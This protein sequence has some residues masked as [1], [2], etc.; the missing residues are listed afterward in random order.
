[1]AR[2]PIPLN[3]LRA[4]EAAARHQSI[5][6]AALELNVSASAVSHQV[7]QL[8]AHLGASL[9][10][11]DGR[12]VQLT[13]DGADLLPKLIDGFKLLEEA[14]GEHQARR[15][16]G[17]LRLSVLDIFA[18]GWLLPRLSGYPLGRQGF[19]LDIQVSQ[20][21][22]SFETENID[23]AVRIG[24]GRWSGLECDHLFDER[25]GVYASPGHSLT[26]PPIFVSRYRLSEWRD[27]CAGP[28]PPASAKAPVVLVENISLAL[29]AALEGAGLCFAGDA[30]AQREV[31]ARRL[32]QSETSPQTSVRGGYWLVY[33][34]R[35]RRDLRLQNLR[36]W[37]FTQIE[38]PSAT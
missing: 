18:H 6:L 4:F 26:Q 21:L 20:Q 30:F 29:K 2:P 14:L 15:S 12:G 7:R 25:M 24:D 11:R 22:V 35:G 8:E 19:E 37:L 1:M 17:P 9:F 5:K 31:E 27:W 34:P 38:P 23:A 3:A 16:Q 32:T 28:T 33:P 36:A 10:H 13:T